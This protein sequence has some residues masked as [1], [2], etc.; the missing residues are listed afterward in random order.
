MRPL[1]FGPQQPGKEKSEL[2]RILGTLALQSE[3]LSGKRKLSLEMIR[4]LHA[5]LGIPAQSL[6][7]A[8]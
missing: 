8:Y 3:I 6:I 2:A 5:V 1:P 4:K 7:T